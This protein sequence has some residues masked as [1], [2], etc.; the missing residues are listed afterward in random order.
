MFEISVF[1]LLIASAAASLNAPLVIWTSEQCAQNMPK[2]TLGDQLS[3]EDFNHKVI[4]PQCGKCAVVVFDTQ[5]SLD[6]LASLAQQNSLMPSLKGVLMKADWQRLMSYKGSGGGGQKTPL[7]DTRYIPLSVDRNSENA[8]NDIDLK[9]KSTLGSLAKSDENTVY[10][11]RSTFKAAVSQVEPRHVIKRRSAAPRASNESIYIMNN[12][13]LMNCDKIYFLA[14]GNEWKSKD[15]KQPKPQNISG[16]YTDMTGDK[17]PT[18]NTSFTV[19]MKTN[20]TIDTLGISNIQIS[21]VIDTWRFG[22]SENNKWFKYWYAE[23]LTLSFTFSSKEHSYP[24]TNGYIAAPRDKSYACQSPDIWPMQPRDDI[25]GRSASLLF[26]NLQFDV[27][28]IFNGTAGEAPALRTGFSDGV[29]CDDR[30]GK[31]GVVGLA[32]LVLVLLVSLY[33]VTILSTAQNP[34][35]GDKQIVVAQE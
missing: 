26:Q 3:D 14:L 19:T 10:V 2:F 17:C 9:L 30:L 1:I 5:I 24:L 6:D 35:F 25:K 18:G 15:G 29:D 8:A 34:V 31:G 13:F 23:N 4:A 16:W 7:C 12:C 33:V 22:P 32:F 20:E 27:N 11:I 28:L 21:M